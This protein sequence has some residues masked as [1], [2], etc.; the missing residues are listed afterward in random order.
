LSYLQEFPIDRVKI[1]QSFVE[2]LSTEVGRSLTGAIISLAHDLGIGVVAEGVETREQADFLR[3][4]GCDE[5]QGFLFSPALPAEE[6]ERYL[7]REKPE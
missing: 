7:E 4:R 2:R 6:F 3:D 1:D 5:L